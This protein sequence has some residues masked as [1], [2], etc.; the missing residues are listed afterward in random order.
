MDP[1]SLH[2]SVV[3]SRE[4][5]ASGDPFEFAHGLNGVDQVGN[6]LWV[7]VLLYTFIGL[8]AMTLILRISKRL[9]SHL[10]HLS[11]MGNPSKQG[12][13][14]HHQN[15][16]IP[17]LKKHV[18]YA[19]LFRHRHNQEFQLSEAVTMGTLP[20]RFHTLLLVIYV[21]SNIAYCLA[22]PWSRAESASVIAALRGRSGT[23][24][25]LNLIPTVLFALRNNPLIWLLQVSYDTFNLLHRWAARLVILE[26]FVHTVAWAVNTF[27]GGNWGGLNQSLGANPS[28]QWGLVGTCAFVFLGIQA[29]SPFRHAFY[30]TFLNIHKTMV[31]VGI[32]GVYL[33][34][35]IHHLPQKPWMHL[36]IGL[37]VGEYFFRAFRIIYY[38][39]SARAVTRITVEALPSEST[40]VTFDLVRPWNPRPGQHVH[41]YI[42]KLA[43]W[44]SHPFSVA[45]WD[46]KNDDFANEKLPTSEIDLDRPAAPVT[47]VS[48]VCRA[49]T[50]LTRKMY[51]RAAACPNG[52][53]TTWGA[54]EGP[55]GGL[56][57]LNSYGTVVLF[58][59]GIGITHQVSYLRHFLEGYRAGTIATKKVLLVWSIPNT[60]CLEWVRPWM[61][62]VLQM[63]LRR[64]M[65]RM[66]LFITRPR[67]ASEAV[68]A[69][70]SVRMFAG[71]CTTQT[72]IDKEVSDRVGAMAITVCGPGRFCDSVR[73]AA[74]KRVEVGAVDFIEEAFTY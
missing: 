32:I 14:E 4:N 49:R 23:L 1:T 7:N 20:S 30:E 26:S 57:S 36:V 66:Q 54:L 10:R 63:P 24:A 55:Y 11:V 22:L 56:E 33:H 45:W 38:N 46:R 34:I 13:W 61:D 6:Y 18:T 70:G 43:L 67:F 50:G 41:M 71:R 74:R 64:D 68:S 12:Y 16:W 39:F 44:S 9:N 3:Q 62:E 59:A 52:K 51:D 60:D 25:A 28:Y 2:V 73:S 8:C 40:R 29:W 31:I 72:I 47:T 21:A 19:P 65:L 48:L 15:S 37:W 27:Q 5:N 42:P 17:W 58:A 53:F 35:D 69:S